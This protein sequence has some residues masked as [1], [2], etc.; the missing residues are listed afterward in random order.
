MKCSSS[1]SPVSVRQK[2]VNPALRTRRG[3]G[4]RRKRNQTAGGQVAIHSEMVKA[5]LRYSPALHR[6]RE[7]ALM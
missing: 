4:R 1:F 7:R 2:K 5:R 3:N 6:I